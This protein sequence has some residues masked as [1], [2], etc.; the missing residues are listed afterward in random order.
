MKNNSGFFVKL[1]FAGNRNIAIIDTVAYPSPPV[2]VVL[3]I[4]AAI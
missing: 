1:S 4:C 2:S 3:T